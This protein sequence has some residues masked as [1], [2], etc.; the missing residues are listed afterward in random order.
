MSHSRNSHL[1]ID[2]TLTNEGFCLQV[3]EQIPLQGITA[4]CGPSGAG[5]T[6]LLRCIAG[7]ERAKGEISFG[8]QFWQQGKSFVP[9]HKRGIGYVFQEASLFSHLSVAANLHYALKRAQQKPSAADMNALV[10]L[11]AIRPLLQRH[12]DTL[13]GGERQ[14]VALTRALLS[15]P[16]IL[17]MDEPLSSL[18][19]ARKQE[20]LPYLEKL[21]NLD[22]PVVYV[23]HASQEIA[24]LADH[25]I[26]MENGKVV[27]SAALNDALMHPQ[28]PLNA[29]QQP[30]V[31]LRGEVSEIDEQWQLSAT[32]LCGSNER[33]WVRHEG[34]PLHSQVRIHVLAGDVSITLSPSTDSS[35]QNIICCTLHSIT[36]DRQP[37]MAML[38]LQV[39]EQWLLARTTR[40]AVEQLKLHAGMMV[41]AQIKSAALL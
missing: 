22:I 15:N 16:R 27:V 39:G 19:E 1:H 40:R 21:R 24:R 18:D 41:W 32:T 37:A 13:S 6:T 30:G 25:V 2:L 4:I 12:P 20:I 10:D 11:M 23:T 38:H 26:A 28:F 14:R 17:L 33:L 29:I 3:S 7:L 8:E 9:T 34:H 31:V 5:K 36:D 35:I